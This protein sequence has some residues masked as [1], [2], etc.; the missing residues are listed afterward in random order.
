MAGLSVQENGPAGSAATVMLRGA[1]SEHT[2]VML[3]GVEV[4]DPISPSRSYD[5]GHLRV[6]SVERVEV[7][8]GPQSPLYGS[9]ALG[10]V[11]NIITRKGQGRPG[12]SVT[13]LAGS[14]GT[15]G[16]RAGFSGASG[17]MN[18]FLDASVLSSS[19]FSAASASYRGNT[20]KDGYRNLALSGRVGYALNDNLDL[21]LI[22][23][24]TLART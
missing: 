21:D 1:N 6:E 22:L 20:E 23:R 2:L 19:G 12:L 17:K 14:Y 16:G 18:F 3:D 9:D 15:A 4:N 10:G 7:I 24:G 11:I 13:A 8:L 5:F